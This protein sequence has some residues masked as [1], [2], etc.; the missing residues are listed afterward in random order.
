MHMYMHTYIHTNV[1][2]GCTLYVVCVLRTQQQT[3]LTLLLR[4]LWD[5]CEV[6]T[7]PR[8]RTQKV[9]LFC[10]CCCWCCWK[11]MNMKRSHTHAAPAVVALAVVLVLLQFRWPFT[12]TLL[13][14]LSLFS[15]SL[16]VCGGC[17]RECVWVRAFLC[18]NVAE[19][20]F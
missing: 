19:L 14:C 20:C 6:K 15:L 2:G 12:S 16:Y 3:T 11:L 1:C 5:K 17:M 8:V 7:A 4:R 9:G 13:T 10:C 18:Q